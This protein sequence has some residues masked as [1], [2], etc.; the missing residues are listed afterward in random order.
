MAHAKM[1]AWGLSIVKVKQMKKILVAVKRVVD[2][3]IKVRL[4]PDHSGVDTKLAKMAINPFDEIAV[5]EAV[6]LK[7]KGLVEE[8]VAVTVGPA[9]AL[10]QLRVAM[11]IGADRGIHVTTDA[12]LEP[13]AVAKVLKVVCERET[14]DLCLLGKQAIDDDANQVGQMLSALLDVPVA[15]AASALS[16]EEGRWLVTRETEGGTQTV[17]LSAPA[18]VTADLRLAQPRYVTL[19]AMGKARKKPVET[20]ELTSLGVDVTPRNR[21]LSVEQ[22]PQKAAGVKVSNVDE[23]IEK[24]KNTAHVL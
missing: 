20:L 8:V 3:K 7:E 18:V 1:G 12:E 10:D 23:L 16:V 22:P 9:K 6:Q 13:L 19:P 24:L 15:P 21:V 4:L 14:P 5:E 17:S 2:A 11:A